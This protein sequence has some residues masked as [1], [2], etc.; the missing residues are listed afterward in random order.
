M[1][2]DEICPGNFICKYDTCIPDLGSCN[3][4]DDC[5]GDSYCDDDMQCIPYDVP[6]DKTNDPTCQK[7]DLP[8]GVTP[9][10]QCEWKGPSD[11]NDPTYNSHYVYTSPIIA[12]LNLDDDPK[13]LQ[14]SII[15][16]TWQTLGGS[17][18]GTLR[19]FDGR[20]CEEQMRI[21][22]A[23]ENTSENRP[24]YGAQLAVADLNGDVQNNGHPEIVGLHR[25]DDNTAS[26]IAY[27]IDN[28]DLNNPKLKR[29]W[30]GRDCQNNNQ[31]VNF[32]TNTGSLLAGPSIIDLNDDGIPEIVQDEVVFGANGCLLS[33]PNFNNYLS[34]IGVQ[35][36]VVDVDLDGLPDLVRY[37]KIAGWNPNTTEWE[38][39]NWFFQNGSQKAG[40]VAIANFGT[41]STLQGKNINDLPEVAVVSASTIN[42][43][44]NDNG[45]VRLMALNGSTVWG[46]IPL[47]K[48]NNTW[49]GRG[50]PPTVSDFDNDGQVEIAAAG[51]NFFAVYDPDCG[52]PQAQRPGGK[53]DRAPEMANM[54]DGVLWA[55]P[56]RDASSNVTGSSVFD[57]D[58]DGKAEVVYRDECWAR[59]YDGNSG[60][61]L[62][63]APGYSLTGLEYPTIADVDGDFK[64]EIVVPRS[65]GNITC[66][67][68]D[69]LFPDSGMIVK[70]SG[71]VVYRDP[72]DRWGNSRPIW[73]Q[74]SY[75]ITHINDDGS[76]VKSSE[77]AVNWLTEGL[78]N[79]RQNV[80]GA[81]GLLDIADLTVEL[82]DLG[83][84]C[85]FGGGNKTLSAEV[86][87]RGTA[88][89]TDGVEVAFYETD[90]VDD[91]PPGNLVC[92]AVTQT[93]L[94]PGDC[95][96]VS[97]DANLKGTGNIYVDVDPDDMISDCHPGNN[98]GA[99]AFDICPG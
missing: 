89:V 75:S 37:N 49:A 31:I 33:A 6:P 45:E 15:V 99:D 77:I 34:T 53:C 36:A 50:G 98:F 42:A 3:D 44:A 23:D 24:G 28:A 25:L 69:P 65:K 87:N 9:V 26:M 41:Y 16:T 63:S 85:D 60:K 76:V 18:L 78:N 92:T 95:E 66:D 39:K 96:I 32:G 54:P 5:P 61:V 83:K 30:Y 93:L 59:V 86:C 43:P 29:L 4:Y 8:D 71:F 79:F 82:T 35:S 47:Y 68:V 20:T 72:G 57:F 55:Q 81:F 38:V 27:E 90:M 48:G 17:R 64:S 7:E 56:S 73:N 11:M 62:F 21:G 80:Q 14:P 13:K 46:P 84:L 74:H 51:A 19:V 22:G 70:E 52:P 10:V 88:P 58:G 12:D 94:N 1:C 40:F 2:G 91:P 67:N 97:C